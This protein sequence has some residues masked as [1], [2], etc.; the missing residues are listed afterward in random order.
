MVKLINGMVKKSRRMNG[1]KNLNVAIPMNAVIIEKK[2]F[3]GLIFVIV[4]HG[5]ENGNF[6]GSAARITFPYMSVLKMTVHF[7][8]IPGMWSF[9]MRKNLKFGDD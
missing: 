7:N 6:N 8:V 9:D 5:G 2:T 4:G 3:N 1:V